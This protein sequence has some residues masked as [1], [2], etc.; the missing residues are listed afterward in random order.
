M[1]QFEP[2]LD[3][4]CL[5][6]HLALL[7]GTRKAVLPVHNTAEKELFRELMSSENTFGNFSS[8]SQVEKAIKIWNAYA[9]TRD[10]VYYKV[11]FAHTGFIN[12]LI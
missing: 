3:S 8:S 5:H 11:F 1:V 7:Q 10:D 2:S 12:I 4:K 6:H 9:D